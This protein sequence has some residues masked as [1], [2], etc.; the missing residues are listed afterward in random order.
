MAR[1]RQVAIWSPGPSAQ[2]LARPSLRYIGAVTVARRIGGQ[3]E[4]V[5]AWRH[6][7]RPQLHMIGS[8]ERRPPGRLPSRLLG[9]GPG[10]G[11]GATH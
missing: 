4:Q 1:N 2:A 7:D 3:Q 9:V 10:V 6:S 8:L 11:A 5:A